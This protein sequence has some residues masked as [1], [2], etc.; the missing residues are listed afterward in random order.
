VS[1]D[2][3]PGLRFSKMHGAG[4]D[5]VVLDRRDQAAPLAPE[6][7][8]WLADRRRGVGCDQVL[9][10]EPPRSAGA[11]FAYGIWNRDGSRAGQCGNG[12]R[13]VAAWARRAGLV[14]DGAFRADSPSGP[15]TA[16]FVGDL[17]EID[18]PP[19]SFDPAV[20]P[21]LG[22]GGQGTLQC[23]GQAIEFAVVSMGNPH[24]LIEVASVADA[25]VERIGPALQ[26]DRR[27]P[28][29]CNVGFAEVC[30]RR[31]I[32]LR[33]YE[34]GVG[35]TLACGSAA[36]AAAVLLIRRGR[37]D[38]QLT[39]ELPGGVL[40][41]HWAGGDAAVRMRGPAEFVFEGEI[42]A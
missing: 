41:I 31:R 16:R 2:R 26:T 6:L 38:H 13:C 5:F 39:V 25:E 19:P 10:I 12:A 21:F 29:S 14:G 32:R 30:D 37:V 1:V 36:C 22:A 23:A 20:V 27:F 4:N 33:V 9:T 11:A 40:G 35:E 28:D 34:R 24:A 8:A 17:V 7:A 42:Q 18:L 3:P 15:I